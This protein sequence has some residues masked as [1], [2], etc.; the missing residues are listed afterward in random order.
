[1]NPC[2]YQSLAVATAWRYAAWKR[3][4]STKVRA[5]LDRAPSPS[6][7]GKLR[8]SWFHGPSA[9]SVSASLR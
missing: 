7:G 8:G 5:G 6:Q 4:P 3:T 2:P 1:M 9:I